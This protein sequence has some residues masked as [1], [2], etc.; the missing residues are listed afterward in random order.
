MLSPR[1]P[2]AL[3]TCRIPY[4]LQFSLLEDLDIDTL[5]RLRRTCH[6]ADEWVSIEL[7]KRLRHLLQR[8]I[9]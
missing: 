5:I 4:D 6:L 3:F 1:Q 7:C 9:K 2:S 8:F